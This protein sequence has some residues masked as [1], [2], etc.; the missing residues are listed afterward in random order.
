M[1]P[2]VLDG[3]EDTGQTKVDD[4][5]PVGE[6]VINDRREVPTAHIAQE[7]GKNPLASEC[8]NC[9]APDTG[10]WSCSSASARRSRKS[11]G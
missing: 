6:G 2:G 9:S 7:L 11:G 4:T 10:T 3:E 1:T 8:L 5:V